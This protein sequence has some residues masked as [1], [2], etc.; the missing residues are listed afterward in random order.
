MRLSPKAEGQRLS[1]CR[2]TPPKWG[3]AV[4]ARLTPR[5]WGLEQ[6]AQANHVTREEKG[7]EAV[8]AENPTSTSEVY[9]YIPL[10]W[11]YCEKTKWLHGWLVR[12]D[13]SN[14]PREVTTDL[15]GPFPIINKGMASQWLEVNG[16]WEGM[17]NVGGSPW[18]LHIAPTEHRNSATNGDSLRAFII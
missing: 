3:T 5:D 4:R 1:R 6:Q 13:K 17:G 10:K 9:G 12:A 7:D 11:K 16:G 18:V 14:L 2:W 8:I 15:Q